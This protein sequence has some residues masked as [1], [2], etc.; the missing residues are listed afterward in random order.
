MP[1]DTVASNYLTLDAVFTLSVFVLVIARISI[2]FLLFE[3]HCSSSTSS[4]YLKMC[5]FSELTN[6]LV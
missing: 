4:I 1:T 2:L 3:I 6:F 5:N